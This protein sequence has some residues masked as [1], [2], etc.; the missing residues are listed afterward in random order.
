MAGQGTT[1][2][3]ARVVVRSTYESQY[4]DPIAFRA[5]DD[6]H[7]HRADPEF[8]EWYWCT[9]PAGKE[10]WVH[11]AYLSRRAGVAAALEDYSARELNER[12]G[13]CGRLLRL[14]GGWAYIEL[15]DGRAGWVPDR[16]IETAA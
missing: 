14:L 4:S 16:I 11:E 2:E 10:G 12:A 9:G 5:G 7:V 6:V 15:D 3:G 1:T 8:P 13:A